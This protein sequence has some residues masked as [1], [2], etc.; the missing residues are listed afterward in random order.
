MF[1]RYARAFIVFPGGFGTMDE[2]FEILVLIQ[3]RKVLHCPVILY[4]SRYWADLI[5]WICKTM[6]ATNKIQPED[7]DL[8][9]LSDDPQEICNIVTAAF[10][11]DYCQEDTRSMNHLD[12]LFR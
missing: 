1:I 6:L 10:Q 7:A 2:L 3:T 11:P 12:P 4:D 5:A 8:L 9:L